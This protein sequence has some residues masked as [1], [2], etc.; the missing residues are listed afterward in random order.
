MKAKQKFR[1]VK[2]VKLASDEMDGWTMS[3][4]HW[5]GQLGPYIVFAS[6]RLGEWQNIGIHIMTQVVKAAIVNNGWQFHNNA[7]PNTWL[8]QSKALP[9][10]AK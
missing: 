3:I 9:K 8:L 2:L 4:V 5:Y 6:S 7:K 1:K 10:I